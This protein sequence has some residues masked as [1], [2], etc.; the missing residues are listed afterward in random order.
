MTWTFVKTTTGSWAPSDAARNS[1]RGMRFQRILRN[2]DSLIPGASPGITKLLGGDNFVIYGAC[3]AGA[4][5]GSTLGRP[6]RP[7]HHRPR[8]GAGRHG[9]RVRRRGPP[10]Q[11]PG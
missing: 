11:P 1:A 4:R 6:G 3:L 5:A 10:A 7:L 9:Y 8:A 2:N